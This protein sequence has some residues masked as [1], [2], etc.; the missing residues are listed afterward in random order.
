MSLRRRRP[1]AASV[2]AQV[3][4]GG[5][6]LRAVEFESAANVPLSISIQRREASSKM[7]QF[8]GFISDLS[9][10]FGGGGSANGNGRYRPPEARLSL[11]WGAN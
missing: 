3:S 9:L 7:D 6:R 5:G 2:M 8:Y 4:G 1:T 11:A 10:N